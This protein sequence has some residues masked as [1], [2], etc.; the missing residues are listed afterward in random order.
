ML[1]LR[2]ILNFE[3]MPSIDHADN[4]DDRHTFKQRIRYALIWACRLIRFI[5]NV[6]V[7]DIVGKAVDKKLNIV[8]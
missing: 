4:Q 8:D 2:T 3:F 7:S 6:A 5:I 1:S